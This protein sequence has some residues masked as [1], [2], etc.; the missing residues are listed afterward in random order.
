MSTFARPLLASLSQTLLFL[1]FVLRTELVETKDQDGLVDLEAEDLRLDEGKRP[2]VNLDEA[3][4]SLY[5]R[6]NL[7]HLRFLSIIMYL[8]VGDSCN[9]RVSDRSVV[10]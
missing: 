3:L 4:A 8:A 2:A 10:M 7:H 9:D 5:F 6:V 1:R